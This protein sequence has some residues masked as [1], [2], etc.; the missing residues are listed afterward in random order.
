VLIGVLANCFNQDIMFIVIDLWKTT[1]TGG[2]VR[3]TSW[4]CG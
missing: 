4:A 1:N 2:E 3:G